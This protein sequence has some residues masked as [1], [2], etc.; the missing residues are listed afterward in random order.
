MPGGRHL[1]PRGPTPV[2]PEHDAASLEVGA[3]NTDWKTVYAGAATQFWDEGLSADLV[4][5]YR[6]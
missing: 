5:E 6:V 1:N 3:S 4:H 2:A